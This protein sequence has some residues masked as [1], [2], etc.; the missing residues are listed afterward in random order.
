MVHV[1]LAMIR[2]TDKLVVVEI[3]M[4]MIMIKQNLLCVKKKDAKKDIII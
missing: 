3:A 2:H 4:E 1:F